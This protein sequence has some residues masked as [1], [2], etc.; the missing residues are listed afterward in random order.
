VQQQKRNLAVVDA[1][2]RGWPGVN[3]AQ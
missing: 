2:I 3:D 1:T